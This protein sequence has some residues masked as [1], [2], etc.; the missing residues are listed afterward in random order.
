M[1]V[2][3]VSHAFYFHVW[4]M[5]SWHEAILSIMCFFSAP[6][7][8]GGS[9]NE[10]GGMWFVWPMCYIQHLVAGSFF[11]RFSAVISNL[12]FGEYLTFSQNLRIP[13]IYQKM[14]GNLQNTLNLSFVK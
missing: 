6:H 1:W 10:M 4:K 8:S 11:G 9:V 5:Q 14:K 3:W 7:F 12:E 13:R 2:L